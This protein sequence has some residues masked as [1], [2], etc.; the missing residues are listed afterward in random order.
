[1][2]IT[3]HQMLDAVENTLD[4]TAG[5]VRTFQFDQ[6]PEGVNSGDCPLLLVHPVRM[7]LVDSLSGATDR[8]TFAGALG[9]RQEMYTVYADFYCKQRSH[10]GEDMAATVAIIDAATNILEADVCPFFG[11]DGIKNR[12]WEWQIVEFTYASAQYL[13]VRF[14]I[15]LRTF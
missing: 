4:G 12:Q 8:M 3:L 11:L 2:A 10:L 5:L 14:T 6:L 13:G 9:V 1:M 15:K 7:E